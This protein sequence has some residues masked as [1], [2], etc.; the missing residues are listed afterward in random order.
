MVDTYYIHLE[1]KNK[2]GD[3]SINLPFLCDKCGVCCTLDD[4]LNAG[5][6]HGSPE[7]NPEAHAKF[8]ALKEE[9]GKIFEK[10]EEEYDWHV[11][12]TKCPFQSGN[13]CSIYEIRPDGCR[14]FPNTPFGMLSEDC[15]AL[16]RFKKQR[17]ALKRGRLAKETSHFTTEPVKPSKFTEEQFQAC[18]CKLR[19]AGATEDELAFFNALNKIG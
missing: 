14:Q 12:H 13:V 10:G 16:D 17:I 6:T 18:L 1:F 8:A 15:K 3:W 5:E 4:F 7:E 19:R 2:N 9:L 11:T